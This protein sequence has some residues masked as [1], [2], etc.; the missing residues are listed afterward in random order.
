MAEEKII[1]Q[2]PNYKVDTDGNVYSKSVCQKNI[3]GEW[4]RV[5]G[6]VVKGYIKCKIRNENGAKLVFAH[7][8]VAQAF[9]ENPENKKTVNHKNGNKKDNRKDNLEWATNKEQTAHAIENNL[10]DFSKAAIKQLVKFEQKD[11]LGNHIKYCVGIENTAKSLG[12]SASAISQNL[13][14][15]S[16]SCLGFNFNYI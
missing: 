15:I 7:R 5:N 11:L 6:V 16:R 2:Y 9:I 14:G 1:S 3:K 13:R 8:L 4:R 12:V 10:L